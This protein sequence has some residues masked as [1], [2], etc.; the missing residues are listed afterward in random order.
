[1][2]GSRNPNFKYKL[3]MT[4][5]EIISYLLLIISIANLVNGTFLESFQFNYA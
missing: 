1:M 2:S 5:N 4:Q 3:H